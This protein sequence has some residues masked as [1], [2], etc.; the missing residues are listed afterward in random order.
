M[1]TAD[2]QSTLG[3]Y[4]QFD[5]NTGAIIDKA[6]EYLKPEKLTA[7]LEEHKSP[8][9]PTHLTLS[10][11]TNKSI[12]TYRRVRRRR[13]LAGLLSPLLAILPLLSLT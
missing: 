13:P 8:S 6:T 3:K 5:L 9:P 11:R 2:A 1:A 10:H 4:I 12:T 7:L